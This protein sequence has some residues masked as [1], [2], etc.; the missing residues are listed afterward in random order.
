MRRACT[1]GRWIAWIV[2]LVV[3]S[4]CVEQGVRCTGP[5][6]PI[7]TSAA[8]TSRS[9]PGRADDAAGPP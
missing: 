8:W 9:A 1:G 3:T 4:G 7:N 5:L 2:L 6:Q